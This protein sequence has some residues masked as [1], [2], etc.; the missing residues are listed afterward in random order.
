MSVIFLPLF[1]AVAQRDDVQRSW[2]E[3]PGSE[4]LTTEA[5]ALSPLSPEA[6]ALNMRPWRGIGDNKKRGSH[7]RQLDGLEDGRRKCP[8]YL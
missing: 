8:L 1:W 3:G 5:L 6:L 7:A 4:A 2:P